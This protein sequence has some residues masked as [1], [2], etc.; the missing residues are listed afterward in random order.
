MKFDLIELLKN[1]KSKFF[2]EFIYFER[3]DSTNTFLLKRHSRFDRVLVITDFQTSGRGRFARK[4]ISEP[5]KNLMFSFGLLIHKTEFLSRLNFWVTLSILKAIEELFSFKAEIKWPND[6]IF[7][8]KKFSG[9]LIENIINEKEAIKSVIGC[10]INVNQTEFPKELIDK[11]TSLKLLLNKEISREILLARIIDNL[12]RSYISLKEKFSEIYNE[13]KLN[14][15][16][17]GTNISITDGKNVWEGIFKN[18]DFNG[19]LVLQSKNGIKKFSSGEIT[20]CKE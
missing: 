5:Y 9:I 4:W 1:S 18:V 11:T 20:I 3:V 7:N 12:D 2:R 14:C 8:G 16:L 13:W 10:G 17:L 19:D 15:K 6:L